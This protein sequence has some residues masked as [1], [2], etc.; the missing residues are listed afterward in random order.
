MWW[1]GGAGERVVMPELIA[2]A[3]RAVEINPPSVQSSSQLLDPWGDPFFS[4][5]MD[6]SIFLGRFW[7]GGGPSYMRGNTV[8]LG[9]CPANY[10]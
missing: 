4:C 7:Y 6:T 5:T 1:H 9:K 3:P 8:P 2:V 10:C